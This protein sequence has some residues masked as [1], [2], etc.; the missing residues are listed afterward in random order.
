MWLFLLISILSMLLLD[1]VCILVLCMVLSWVA[2]VRWGISLLCWVRLILI[3]I[4]LMAGG[5]G[6]GAV[7]VS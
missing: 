1:L 4:G 5:P 2:V 3:V 7:L 6:I